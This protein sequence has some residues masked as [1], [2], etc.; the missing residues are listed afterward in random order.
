MAEGSKCGSTR[1][2]SQPARKYGT[3]SMRFYDHIFIL[4]I[5]PSFTRVRRT[6]RVKRRCHILAVVVFHGK[7]D[8]ISFS[9]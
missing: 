4:K 9:L 1:F 8:S 7:I 5:V 6:K 2:L 3:T